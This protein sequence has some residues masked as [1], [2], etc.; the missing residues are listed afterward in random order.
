MA[1]ASAPEDPTA[2]R[3]KLAGEYGAAAEVY[4][5]KWAA[6][7]RATVGVTLA[8]LPPLPPGA[9]VLDLACG[10]GAL[11]HAL[12][13]AGAPLGAYTGLD[14]SDGMLAVAAR[15][16]T[17][18]SLPFTPTWVHGGADAPLPLAD[19]S[20]DAVLCANSFHFFGDKAHCLSEVHRVLKPGGVVLISDW[21]SD[22]FSCRAL[23][24]WLRVSGGATARV[25]RRAEL[26]ALLEA[27]PGL[28]VQSVTSSRLL[29]WW[30]F[31][32]ALA[33]KDGGGDASA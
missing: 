28:R 27:Q 23:E 31:M 7:T 1:A 14:N 3:S 17:A 2:L 33:R 29:R 12:M 20:C 11:L 22:Y 9:A 10:T 26:R 5:T 16:A 19:A 15:R 18:A 30:G 6:Y 13:A 32:V 25:L 21:C 24:F 4:D 8:A